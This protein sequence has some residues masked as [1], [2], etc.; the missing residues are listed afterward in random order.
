MTE[1]WA[2]RD[3]TSAP[4]T[5]YSVIDLGATRRSSIT[6]SDGVLIEQ[7]TNDD[8]NSLYY[9]LLTEDRTYTDSSKQTMLRRSTVNWARTGDPAQDPTNTD[10]TYR[11]PRPTRTEVFDDRGQMTATDYY[12]G[13]SGNYYNQV[14]DKIEYGY[15]GTAQ[16]HRT[17]SEYENGTFYR[18]YWINR[19]TIW[20]DGGTYPGWQGA[21]IFTL[22]K[23][24]KVYA[25]DNV[26]PVAHRRYRYDESSLVARPG[27]GQLASAPTERGNLTTVKRYANAITLDDGTAVV[28]TRSYD[29]CGNVATLATPSCCEQTSFE[30]HVDT[31]Y[32]CQF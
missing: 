20:F 27:A 15:G 2:G 5:T 10:P 16:L 31:R 17:Y 30:F 12:Y 7:D 29:V 18:G 6:R 9:G 28:E 25:A 8:P 24:S 4:V 1:D 13:T 11:S 14:V 23:D 22:V 32:G 21:H 19:N 26:T 3:T